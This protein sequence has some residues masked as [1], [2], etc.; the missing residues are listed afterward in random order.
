MRWFTATSLGLTTLMLAGCMDVDL[1][2]ISDRYREDFHFSYPLNAG[3]SLQIDNMNGAVQIVGWDKNTVDI[4]GTKYASSED[5]L[6]EVQ[7]DVVHSPDS[8]SIRTVPP[9][10]RSGNFGARY[11]IHVPQ[12]VQLKN[13]VSTNGAIRVESIEGGAQLKT[14]NGA[15]E[16][17]GLT[18]D[19]TARTTNGSIRADVTKGGFEAESTNGTISARLRE[20]GSGPVRAETTNGTIDLTLD[21][22]RA[23]HANTSNGSITVHL[24]AA[25]AASVRAHTTNSSISS[26]F[27]VNVHSGEISKH[28]MEGNIGSGG[29]TLDLETTNG[30]IKILKM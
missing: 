9:A 24:P 29:P 17:T 19:A 11:T 21:A 23:V 18:G 15:I 6:K 13:V 2:G 16:I 22:V 1:G 7:I 28:R 5:R 8:V 26:D 10:S 20:P 14:S 27:D 30:S 4:D 12:K 25:A 3:G